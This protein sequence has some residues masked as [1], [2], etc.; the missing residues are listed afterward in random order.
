M[1]FAPELRTP[2]LGATLSLT[3]VITGALGAAVSTWI[4]KALLA[5]LTLP[6]A[7]VAVALRVWGP[8]AKAAVVNVKVPA[9]LSV[10]VPK[11]VVPS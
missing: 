1:V 7:S 2:V 4:E 5:G 6:A 8:A 10:A 3:A 11:R 9:G